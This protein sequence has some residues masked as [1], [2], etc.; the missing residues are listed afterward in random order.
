MRQVLEYG[1]TP[2]FLT[3]FAT[4]LTGIEFAVFDHGDLT[5]IF[6]NNEIR[7]TYRISFLAN[8]LAASRTCS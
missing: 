1:A 8:C 5:A 6:A 3:N 4:K 2:K 7:D